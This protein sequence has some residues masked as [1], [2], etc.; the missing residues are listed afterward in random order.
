MVDSRCAI[1]SEVLDFIKLDNASSISF[2]DS[3]SKDDVASSK[4]K[5]SGFFKI[6]L[7]ILILCFCPPDS[8][9]PA[10]PIFV[11]YPFSHFRINSSALA[12]FAACIISS[13][14]ALRLPSFML[15]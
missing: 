12:A 11:S 7:A 9:S 13:L 8:F 2:S 14:L 1:T 10:F 5:M 6:A 15:L 4:I 3:E